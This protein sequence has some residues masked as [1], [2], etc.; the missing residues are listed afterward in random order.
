[1]SVN[2][3]YQKLISTIKCCLTNRAPVNHLT[4]FLLEIEWNK[5]LIELNCNVHPLEAVSSRIKE[6]HACECKI[7]STECVAAYSTEF[8]KIQ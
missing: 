2:N 1:M 8:I 6:L 3:T 7:D 5:S 4:V